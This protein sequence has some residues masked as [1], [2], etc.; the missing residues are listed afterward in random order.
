VSLLLCGDVAPL[1]LD[2]TEEREIGAALAACLQTLPTPIGETV[3]MLGPWSKLA[4]T[5]GGA[6]LKRMA[7]IT[8]ARAAAKVK[9]PTQGPRAAAPTVPYAPAPNGQTVPPPPPFPNAGDVYAPTP[10]QL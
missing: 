5:L 9:A 6:I 3:G 4:S 7:M 10:V 1:S 8:T 2:T